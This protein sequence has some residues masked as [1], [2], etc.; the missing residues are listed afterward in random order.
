MGTKLHQFFMSKDSCKYVFRSGKTA[1]FEG[2]VYRTTI[3]SEIAELIEQ[4][5]AGI[6]AIWQERGQEVVDSD[7]IDPVAVFKRKIIAEYEAEKAR[8]LDNGTSFSDSSASGKPTGTKAMGG[9]AA[10]STS[11]AATVVGGVPA[12]SIKVS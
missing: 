5:A 10:Q 3:D 12:G 6:G 2:G 9:N 8:S 1:I 4:I 11:G 7:D